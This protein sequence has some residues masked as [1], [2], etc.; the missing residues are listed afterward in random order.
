MARKLAPLAW[1]EDYA[2]ID[3]RI[4]DDPIDFV[5]DKIDTRICFGHDLY[6][7]YQVDELFGDKLIAVA[8]PDFLSRFGPSVQDIPDRYLIHTD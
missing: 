2:L 5:Q 3:I 4:D 1:A 6:G 8:S 7:D